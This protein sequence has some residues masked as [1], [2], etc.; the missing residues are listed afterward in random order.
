MCQFKR[1]FQSIE[2]Y[3]AYDDG[4]DNLYE[5]FNGELIEVP[6]E[7][8]KLPKFCSHLQKS[9]TNMKRSP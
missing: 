2:E 5:L 4:T 1:R 7:S 9:L 3:F 6:P 8:T